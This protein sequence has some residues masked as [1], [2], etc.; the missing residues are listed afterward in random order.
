[1]RAR[2]R[3]CVCVCVCVCV[4]ACACVCVCVGVCACVFASVR[5][6]VHHKNRRDLGILK[7]SFQERNNI[8][9]EHVRLFGSVPQTT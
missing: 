1:M 2:A 8:L 4:R 5:A 6:R 9:I 3:A 7:V